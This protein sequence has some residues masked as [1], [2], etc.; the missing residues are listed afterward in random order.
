MWIFIVDIALDC[1]EVANPRLALAIDWPHF[2]TITFYYNFTMFTINT[3]NS[4]I[5]I[6][7]YSL[8]K[9]IIKLYYNNKKQYT[10]ICYD[11]IVLLYHNIMYSLRV[12][13]RVILYSKDIYSKSYG[14]NINTID[15]I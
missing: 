3:I 12:L 7:F 2:L 11:Y 8:I 1:Q 13:K 10:Y 14:N 6:Y 5:S 9:L 4:L 15:Q